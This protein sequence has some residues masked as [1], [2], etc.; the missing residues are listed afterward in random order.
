MRFEHVNRYAAGSDAV[1][2]MLT[3]PA[4]REEV[5]VRQRAL[6]HDVDVTGAG[7]G[8]VVLIARTQSMQGAPG[9]ATKVVGDTVRIV[10]REEWRTATEADFVMEIPGKPGRLD[11]GIVL[12]D[13]GDGTTDELFSGEVKVTVPLLGRKLEQMIASIL[14][15][16][17]VKEGQVGASWFADGPS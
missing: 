11:G 12:R 9:V 4:F 8:A 2:T 15:R 16:A 5:C 10:Q 1:L 17:L 7:P 6:D 3:T 13:N 14:E